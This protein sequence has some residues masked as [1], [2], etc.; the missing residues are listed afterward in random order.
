MLSN[1]VE[2]DSC[3]DQELKHFSK[4]PSYSDFLCSWVSELIAKSRHKDEDEETSRC[5]KLFKIV[6]IVPNQLIVLE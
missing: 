5:D 6:L 3:A 2:E 1:N 4:K